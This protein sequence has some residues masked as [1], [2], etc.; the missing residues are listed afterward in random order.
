MTELIECSYGK[1]YTEKSNF[2]ESGLRNVYKICKKCNC[3]K[4]KKYRQNNR[5]KY[6]AKV[7]EY[8]R[9]W[10]ANKRAY[11]K[12]DTQIGILNS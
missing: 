12:E 10:I 2:A 5:I 9:Q 3:E 8:Q 11:E 1:H 4:T 6:N 7:R